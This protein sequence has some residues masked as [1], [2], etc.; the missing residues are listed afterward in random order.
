MHSRYDISKGDPKLVE[1]VK[2][3]NATV[4]E[5]SVSGGLLNHLPFLRHIA[6]E[7]SGYKAITDRI[8]RMWSF[9]DVRILKKDSKINDALSLFKSYRIMFFK[10]EVTSHKNTRQ[11]G[12]HRDLIDAYLEEIEARN[13][14]PSSTFNGQVPQIKFYFFS[15]PVE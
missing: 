2:I 8:R 12:V 6:P 7:L 4:K 5:S 9:F 10:D 13:K 15:S 1:T 11:L 3:L 14:D